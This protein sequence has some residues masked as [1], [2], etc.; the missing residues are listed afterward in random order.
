MRM[1][2]VI[3]L[4]DKANKAILLAH[5]NEDADSVGSC[6]AMALALR[7]AGKSAV[8][9][10]SDSVPSHIAFMGDDY[11]IF[12][13]EK[14][15][16]SDLCICLDCGDIDRI[17]KRKKIFD[18]AA[19]TLSIDHHHTNTRFADV[20]YVEGDAASTGEVLYKI[21][22]QANIEI[23]ADIAK[24]LFA[25]ISSDTG[26]FKYSNVSCETMNIAGELIKTGINHTEISRLLHD[27]KTFE[28][29]KFE[30]YVMGS[31][32]RY[33]DGKLTVITAKHEA[34]EKF[35]IDEKNTGDIVDIAKSIEGCMIAVS[36]KELQGKI[37]MSFRSNCQISVS[38]A[39]VSFGG[40]G[41]YMAAGAT[42]S[43][44]TLDE[45]KADVVK[46]FEGLLND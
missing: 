29:I 19:N 26:S 35:D 32:E 44:K 22:K 8:C 21:F 11:E 40:G 14:C 27:T 17:G 33:F 7:N 41:H 4:I 12:D 43:G 24:N 1:N 20:N 45:L 39:A 6:F 18:A 37:K 30:A 13:E 23:T 9:V 2:D 38:D 10:F 28:Q 25:S 5:E 46:T 31:I 42:V 15:Y 36:L 3:K 16:E 34:F